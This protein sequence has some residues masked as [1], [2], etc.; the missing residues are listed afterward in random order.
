MR[1]DLSNA[2]FP[3]PERKDSRSLI[4]FLSLLLLACLAAAGCSAAPAPV[5]APAGRSDISR[6]GSVDAAF[7]SAR[8]DPNA[9]RAFLLAMPKGGD[10]HNHLSGAIYPEV[11]LELASYQGLGIDISPDASGAPRFALKAATTPGSGQPDMTALTAD[12]LACP[13]SQSPETCAGNGVIPACCLCSSSTLYDGAVNAL[14]MRGLP[15]GTLQAHD[16]FF[17]IFGK[18]GPATQNRAALLAQL[19]QQ[20][21]RENVLYLETMSSAPLPPGNPVLAAFQSLFAGG[22]SSPGAAFCA[23]LMADGFGTPDDNGTQ[24]IAAARALAAEVAQT[25]ARQI[26][27][28]S[29]LL[30]CGSAA[31]AS[32]PPGCEVTV[33]HQVELHRTAPPLVICQEALVG[34]ATS[35]ADRQHIVGINIVA[36]EDA[37]VSRIDYSKHMNL[38]GHLG[39]LFRPAGRALHAGELIEG[40]VPPNDLRFHIHDAVA[41]AHAQRIGHG[42]AITYETGSGET[43][44]KMAEEPVAI[45]INLVSNAQLL[46][47]AGDA[48]P[49]PLYVERH[50]PVVLATDD[51]GIMRTTLT[52]QYRLAALDYPRFRYADLRTFNRNS[53]EYSFLT[54]SSIWEDPGHYEHPVMEC[55][56]P[57]GVFD[58]SRCEAW[59]KDHGDK[60]QIQVRFEQRLQAFEEG[61][62]R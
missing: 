24:V 55:R 17:A 42:V 39:T 29:R 30:G 23:Q 61:F 40:L 59:A 20:A 21:S 52:E 54:G 14:S 38:I 48:H 8:Q 34:F 11:L 33:R 26:E 56:A 35:E 12:C 36:A 25:M 43:L 28:S 2:Q 32:A 19:R 62:R 51:P 9:L 60:A 3:L 41:A 22:S 5:T 45:E 49:L 47:I 15:W 16:H 1:G 4:F 44:K 27:D 53:L 31:G 37:Y 57:K 10:L 7:Q 18:L 50:V 6:A 46:G 13:A 58:L